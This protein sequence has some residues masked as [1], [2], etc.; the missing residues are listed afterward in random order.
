[1]HGLLITFVACAGLMACSQDKVTQ[2]PTTSARIQKALVETNGAR[3]GE[4]GLPVEIAYITSGKDR[5][6]TAGFWSEDRNC[7]YRIGGTV[8]D[9]KVALNKQVVSQCGADSTT[10]QAIIVPRNR[11]RAISECQQPDDNARI[12]CYAAVVSSNEQLT[13]VAEK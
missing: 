11:A 3:A 5:R 12:Q 9:G 1:M 6:F 2:G 4:P 7:Q 8:F 13:L 10:I